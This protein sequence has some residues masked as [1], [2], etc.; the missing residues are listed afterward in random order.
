[1]KTFVDT[2]VNI[3]TVRKCTQARLLLPLLVAALWVSPLRQACGGQEEQGSQMLRDI[4]A[5]SAPILAAMAKEH[6][7]GLE[8]GQDLRRVAPPFAQI[9]MEYYRTGHPSQSEAIKEG[10]SAMIFRWSD[11]KLRNLGMTFGDSADPGYTLRDVLDALL[12]I[13]SQQIDDPSDLLET[14]LAGDWGGAFGT[15]PASTD[16]GAII[17]RHAPAPA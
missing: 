2:V 16:F 13:K 1:M 11:G 7:Y 15:L 4:R 3:S 17:E 14:R 10:P 12:D 8:P 9:R 6:G 5:A